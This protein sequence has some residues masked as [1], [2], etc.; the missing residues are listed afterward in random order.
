MHTIKGGAIGRS[1]WGWLGDGKVG[2]GELEESERGARLEV[3][4]SLNVWG[5][6]AFP[7]VP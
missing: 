3:A 5:N 7:G 6:D 1:E 2:V 4:S